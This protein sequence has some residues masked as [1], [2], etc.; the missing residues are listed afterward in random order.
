MVQLFNINKHII[1]TSKF[2]N[3]L[4]DEVVEDFEK[5]IAN[6]VGAKYAC[7][8]NSATN[9]I[10]LSMLNK[11]VVVNLP[12]MIP[13][14]VANAILTSGNKINFIDDV[15]WVG[16]SYML[17]KFD[18]YKIVD[19]AQKLEENQFKKECN[20][21]DLMLFSFY[22]TKPLGGSD[23]GMI[24]TDDYEKYQWFKSA[25]LNGMSFANNN[26]ER[27]I[28]F[29][30]YKMYMNS[31]QAQICLNNFQTF[32]DKMSSLQNLVDIYNRELGYNNSSSHLYRIEV[33]DNQKFINKMRKNHII[34][35]MHY[36]ALH[37]NSVYNNGINFDCKKSKE[38]QLRTV[39]L[40]M[41]ENLKDDEISYVIKKVKES[42]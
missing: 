7:S 1:D 29:P 41:N 26:W 33:T 15:D 23:G 22:P 42:M 27:K 36:S 34:C 40:P 38:L 9:A 6:Y 5:T 11:D 30:G 13:P 39:S 19:S 21:E 2:S 31:I 37:L 4:H 32:E 20:S 12:S 28:S 24:V 3:L 16:D 18:D 17:H 14:V 10:F 35:G 25:V 8:I